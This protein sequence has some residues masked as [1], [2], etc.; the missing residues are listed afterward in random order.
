MVGPQ[1][2]QW[3]KHRLR[4][5]QSMTHVCQVAPVALQP[6]AQIFE[7]GYVLQWRVAADD[8][9]VE[10]CLSYASLAR[11]DGF[12]SQGA[13]VWSLRT[14][15][16]HQRAM[17]IFRPRSLVKLLSAVV[18]RR[19][20]AVTE[21]RLPDIQ[22]GFRPVRGCRD[23]VCALRW[24]IDMVLRESRQA[25]VTFINY[26]AAFDTESQTFLD[27]ALAETGV[28]PKG[29]LM[30]VTEDRLP[31]NQAGCRPAGGCWNNV[32]ALR[33]FIDMVLREGRQ[34]VVTFIDYSVVF[35]TESQL[36]FNSALA[37]TEGSSKVRRIVQAIFA[38]ASGVV[39]I[40]QQDGGVEMSEPLNIERGVLQGIYSRPCASSQS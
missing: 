16:S 21:D 2:A 20:M 13:Y 34:A 4:D 33:W 31:V 12:V 23:N 1:M 30:A 29:R 26:S 14:A 35:D 28:S 6:A 10:G 15:P 18:A 7:M 3:A 32:C 36:F 17:C 8:H 40:R 5:L 9:L 37:E 27:N 11:L 25:V 22:A 38:A 19:L 24:F 39:L